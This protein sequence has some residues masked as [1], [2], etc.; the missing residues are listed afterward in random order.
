MSGLVQIRNVPAEARRILKARA[1][2]RGKS[3]NAY[4]LEMI[5]RE[6]TRPTIE[7]VMKRA[8]TR[9]E[10][11]TATAVGALAAARAERDEELRPWA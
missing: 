5:D 11:A 1:A 8:A 9:A 7:D 2:A 4:L 6:V 10:S 3:L